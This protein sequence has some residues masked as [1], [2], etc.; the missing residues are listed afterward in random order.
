MSTGALA[1]QKLSVCTQ[2][3]L[4]TWASA[5][6]GRDTEVF[7]PEQEIVPVHERDGKD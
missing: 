4:I 5:P 1:S 3:G 7:Q 2:S 6:S